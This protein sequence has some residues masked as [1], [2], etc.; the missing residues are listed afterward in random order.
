MSTQ[1]YFLLNYVVSG[2]LQ[3]VVH[4]VFFF[5]KTFLGFSR[6]ILVYLDDHIFFIITFGNITVKNILGLGNVQ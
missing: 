5:V 1:C 6:V 2:L 3:M 4:V